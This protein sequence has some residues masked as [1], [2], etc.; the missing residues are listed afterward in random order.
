SSTGTEKLTARELEFLE[1]CCSDMSYK[2]IAEKMN[3]MIKTIEY[4]RAVLFQKLKVQNRSG[5]IVRAIQL[6]LVKV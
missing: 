6:K 5:L 2:E 4:H 3:V 1:H